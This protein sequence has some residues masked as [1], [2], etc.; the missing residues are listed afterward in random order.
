LKEVPKFYKILYPYTKMARVRNG[1]I[2]VPRVEKK[3]YSIKRGAAVLIALYIVMAAGCAVQT[4]KL[5]GVQAKKAEVNKTKTITIEEKKK[6]LAINDYMKVAA[7]DGLSGSV[8]VA[9]DGHIIL[10][11]SYGMADKEKK[12]PCTRQTRF[13]IGSLSKQFTSMAIMQLEEKG[14]LS[15]KDNVEKYIPG[16]PH[17]RE[18]T[19]HQLLSHTSGLPSNLNTAIKFTVVPSSLNKALNMIKSKGLKL[20]AEPGEKFSYSNMGYEIL[21]LIIQKVTGETY[22]K[23]VQ[24]NIFDPLGMVNSGFGY[25]RKKNTKLAKSYLANGAIII[26]NDYVNCSF[27]P[28]S[29][30]EI[31]STAEDMYKWDKALYTEKLVSKKTLTKIFTPVLA[32]YGYGWT[33]KTPGIKGINGHS[34]NVFGY[35]GD[36]LRVGKTDSYF[37]ILSNKGKISLISSYLTKELMSYSK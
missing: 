1:R 7:R 29:A 26:K 18:I 19:I 6:A 22:E 10:S 31:Y 2:T 14:L 4:K 9:I 35:Y 28:F 17:G 16:F 15:V 37:I 32:G 34:G 36:E 11:K 33:I 27:V 21:G 20:I 23:Y 5:T 30:A 13:M 3:E 8:L 12:V 24:K 25:N